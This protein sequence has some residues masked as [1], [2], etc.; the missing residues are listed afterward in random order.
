MT[1]LTPKKRQYL[2][3]CGYLVTQITACLLNC[4]ES[5]TASLSMLPRYPNTATSSLKNPQY[6]F[7]QDPM[8]HMVH[9]L[10]STTHRGLIKSSSRLEWLPLVHNVIM[11][12]ASLCLRQHASSW[13]Y[14]SHYQWNHTH[15]MVTQHTPTQSYTGS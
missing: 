6:L 10:Y 5:A 13:S 2:A 3:G 14:S 7:S 11:L 1:I 4:L 8:S 15:L 9:S 12:H